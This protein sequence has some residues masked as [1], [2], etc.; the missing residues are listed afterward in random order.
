L[1]VAEREKLLRQIKVGD[2]FHAKSPS[3]AKMLCLTTAIDDTTIHAR[4]ITTQM[5]HEFDCRTGTEK[6]NSPGFGRIDS[7]APLPPDIRDVFL[8]LDHRYRTSTDPERAILTDAEKRAIMFIASHY[9][10]NPV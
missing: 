8:G 1:I 7:V 9:P 5:D 10:A 4:R 6:G 3:G 2:F